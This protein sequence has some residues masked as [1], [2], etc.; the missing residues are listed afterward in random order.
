MVGEERA[1]EWL[2]RYKEINGAEDP[3]K[4]LKGAKSDVA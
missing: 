4:L 2:H 3:L 1:L